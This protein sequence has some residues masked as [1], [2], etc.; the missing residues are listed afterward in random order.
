MPICD[1]LNIEIREGI[2]LE[3]FYDFV[4]HKGDLRGLKVTYLYVCVVIAMYVHILKAEQYMLL[5]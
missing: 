5:A 1:F 3:P 2:K 4:S